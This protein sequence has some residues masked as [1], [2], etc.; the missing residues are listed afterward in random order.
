MTPK[1]AKRF[2]P[3]DERIEAL[4]E[5]LPDSE[6]KLAQLLTAQPAL[7]ATHSATELAAIA[8]SSKAAVT[9]FIQ[10]VGYDG[11]AS[12]RREAREAQRWGAPGLQAAS[13]LS[14]ASEEAFGEHLRRDLQN[15][16]RTFDKL[17]SG[18]VEPAIT[19]LARARRV[20]VVGYRNSHALAQ[21]FARQ[22]VL[23][24]NHVALLP[25]AGQTIGEDLAAFGPDDMLVILAFRRRVPVVAE[26]A[27]HARKAG[28]PVLVLMD[29]S[30]P[31][32]EVDATWRIA[33][34]ASGSGRFDSYAAAMSVLNLLVSALAHRPEIEAGNRLRAAERLHEGLEEL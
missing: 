24:K 14:A 2:K 1:P 3:I 6:H 11:F 33:C 8:G 21:Y 20:G 30:T 4:S 34:E 12:A 10:R 28:V 31:A 32:K 27:R 23:L 29:A 9:R 18:V 19:S 22:L 16:A 25:Q 15:L 7:L 13:D 5:T 17:T 26:I